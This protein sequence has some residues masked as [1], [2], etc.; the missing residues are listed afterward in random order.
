MKLPNIPVGDRHPVLVAPY[1]AIVPS[2]DS[3]A[4]FYVAVVSEDGG[5]KGELDTPQ[6]GPQ[7]QKTSTCSTNRSASMT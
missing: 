7:I 5:V 1:P 4:A 6:K 3:V 2:E